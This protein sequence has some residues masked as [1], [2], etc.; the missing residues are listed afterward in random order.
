MGEEGEGQIG[1]S[2]YCCDLDSAAYWFKARRM[3]VAIDHIVIECVH[4]ET[5]FCL[6]G[7]K[8]FA[9]TSSLMSRSIDF[10][11]AS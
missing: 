7:P 10:H 11:A 8:C 4:V 2:S 9:L 5:F 3:I 6:Q 1:L